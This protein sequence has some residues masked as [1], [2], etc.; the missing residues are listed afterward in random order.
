MSDLDAN[1]MTD[2]RAQVL[3]RGVRLLVATGNRHKLDEISAVLEGEGV[4]VVGTEIFA[5]AGHEIPP[6]PVEDGETF[7]A[8]AT[9]K[10]RAYA[11][12]VA[13][14]AADERPDFVLADDSGLCVDALGGAPGVHSSRY[15]GEDATDSA[16]NAKLLAAL[17]GVPTPD[18]SAAFHCVMVVVRPGSDA[19]SAPPLIVTEGRCP[20]AIVERAS[21]DAGFGYDPLFFYPP[22]GTTFAEL[23][24]AEKNR[25]SHRG[26]ALAE[27]PGR[28]REIA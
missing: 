17:E 16:N 26:R 11:E 13:T 12:A 8:N 3:G 5:A 14:L 25:V 4:T 23:S 27:L 6:P 18:R 20:G 21:G 7:L 22:A 19:S 24:P 10:A 9:I 2:P 15:A 28:I 1:S